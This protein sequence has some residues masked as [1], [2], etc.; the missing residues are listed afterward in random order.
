M[1]AKSYRDRLEELL[2]DS[3]MPYS[4]LVSRL[5]AIPRVKELSALKILMTSAVKSEQLIVCN[6]IFHSY[7]YSTFF[8][9]SN[10]RQTCS[11]KPKH[12]ENCC[13]SSVI[14]VHVSN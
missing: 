10:V 2:R 11:L 12:P 7:S 6:S 5:T 14:G 3:L 1:H 8:S 9:H 13:Y 4:K